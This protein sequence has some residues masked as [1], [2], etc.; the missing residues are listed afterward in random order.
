MSDTTNPNAA[1]I[2]H[3]N[4]VAGVTWAELGA[5]LDRQMAETGRN[6]MKALAPRHGERLLDVGCGCGWTT[7]DLA[8]AVG[9][10]GRVTGL[11][12]SR[13]QLAVARDRAAEA[14]LS[15][16]VDFV[17][18]DA[19]THPFDAGAFDGLFSR[20]GVM[21]FADPTAAF[22]NLRRALVPGGRLAFLC[23]CPMADNPVMTIPMAAARHRLP[24]M[25]PPTPNAPGPFAFADE[26][27]VRGILEAAGFA[28]VA[29][30]RQDGEMGGNSLED[31]LKV[32]LRVGPLG[33][34]LREHPHL[35]PEAR[36]DVTAAYLPLVRDGAV[37]MRAATWIVTARSA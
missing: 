26:G 27:R 36:E 34:A 15:S 24:P 14:A 21:F 22:Q 16:H 17:E 30:T 33:A 7:L 3:W 29:M 8:R 25:P 32:A 11:D 37:W 2:T 6:A 10:E 9:P 20:F 13:P 18:A 23:W 4:E 1:Q 35:L 5:L 31:S 12:I 19:Q 28:E